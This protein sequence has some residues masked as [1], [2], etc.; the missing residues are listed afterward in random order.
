MPSLVE[1]LRELAAPASRDVPPDI[2][3]ITEFLYIAAHPQDGHVDAIRALGVE[4]IINMIWHRPA[5]ALSQPPF[6]MMTFRTFDAPQLPIPVGTLRK[7]VTTAVPTIQSGGKVLVYCREGRHR[8]VAMACCVLIGMGYTADAAMQLVDEQ[9]AVADPHAPHIESQIR[10][11]EA[12][13]LARQ[14]DTDPEEPT[15]HE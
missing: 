15:E 9:R 11:F 4:L 2:S 8:S 5:K 12:D 14:M 7:G 6:R 1:Q 10:A 13:W 3:E